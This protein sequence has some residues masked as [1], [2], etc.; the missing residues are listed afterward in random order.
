MDKIG[1]LNFQHSN[2]N[3]GAVLQAV[4]LHE[5]ITGEAEYQVE[6]IDY[7]PFNEPSSAFSRIKKALKK[8]MVK[9]GYKKDKI[10][11]DYFLNPYVFENFRSVW[12]PRTSRQYSTIGDLEQADFTYSH[13]IVGS[14][15]VWRPNYTSNSADVYFLE[16]A[17][18][19]VRRISYA[20]SFGND[21]W[22]ENEGTTAMAIEALD[23]FHAVSVREIS[24]VTI[25]S[26]V[27]SVDAVH[28]LDPTLLIGSS[29]FEK[30]IKISSI[31]VSVP[32]VVY[33]KLD[34]NSDFTSVINNV[35]NTLDCD[36]TN[37]YYK[38]TSKGNEYYPVE[39]WLG[40]IR[41]SKI[42]I[43]DSF[44]CICFAILFNKPF[45]CYPNNNRG[46]ARLESLLGELKLKHLI[47]KS[48]EQIPE[49]IFQ[50]NSIDYEKVNS[51]LADL[52]L[53]SANFLINSL[54]E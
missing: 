23:K 4:A 45:I 44:H 2:H 25:A 48:S 35:S 49:L 1:I 12:L 47:L 17:K 14:D 50:A 9:L 16:F 22:V 8:L 53:H 18:P 21:V 10:H 31:Q 29:F 38:P 51:K 27:F 20:A 37:I 39:E 6:H 26:D 52:R 54:A 13:I 46:L 28:V 41:D 15:Q 3:Y 36:T 19:T 32:T 30:I 34:I 42:V 40:F 11:H 7:I 5:F 33:Y 24:G 43:T